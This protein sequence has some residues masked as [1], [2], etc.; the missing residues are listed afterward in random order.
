MSF[1]FADEWLWAKWPVWGILSTRAASTQHSL[2]A[3][4]RSQNSDHI[5]GAP[6]EVSS[7][8]ECWRTLTGID[9]KWELCGTESTFWKV[10]HWW[11]CRCLCNI[12]TES[13]GHYDRIATNK[14]NW[15][16]V[17]LFW[18]SLTM[19]SINPA[20]GSSV[21]FC[22]SNH[23]DISVKN[24]TADLVLSYTV[25]YSLL[26]FRGVDFVNQLEVT[27]NTDIFIG[28]HGAGLT[29]LLFLPKWASIF[30]L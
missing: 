5:V 30:E 6:N 19:R 28:M 14:L 22:C 10:N 4:E 18:M 13:V 25:L 26:L 23:L 3:E 17:Y 16:Y 27:R 15:G 12:R 24:L 8:F 29:H 1:S 9:E 11:H 7:N 20:F 21:S 2:T